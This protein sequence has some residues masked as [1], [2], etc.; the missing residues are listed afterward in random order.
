MVNT[1]WWLNKN[2][3]KEQR[4][5]VIKIENSGFR[6]HKNK[7]HWKKLQGH[8]NL[9]DFINLEELSCEW[10]NLTSFFLNNCSKLRIIRCYGNK[11]TNLSFV[12]QLPTE[13]LT[14]LSVGKIH[15]LPPYELDVFSHLINLEELYLEQ[16]FL[17]S[18]L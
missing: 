12:S 14:V 10:N 4:K 5:E 1:E 18:F 17:I 13:T 16:D 8:L 11:L 15:S 7:Q 3:P 6:H 2:Y 9:A